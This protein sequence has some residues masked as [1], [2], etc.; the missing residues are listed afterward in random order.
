MTQRDIRPLGA[1]D[2][3]AFYW[4]QTSSHPGGSAL[5]LVAVDEVGEVTRMPIRA[6]FDAAA[7][8]LAEAV[9]AHLGRAIAD[10]DREL[11]RRRR[12]AP[13]P[14]PHPSIDEPGDGPVLER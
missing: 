11:E 5:Q 3:K 8:T 2:G 12:E 10:A 1:G 4:V 9:E 7:P 13:E 6:G 14:E